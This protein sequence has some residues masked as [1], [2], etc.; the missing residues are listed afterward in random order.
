MTQSGS[1]RAGQF[2]FPSKITFSLIESTFCS[3]QLLLAQWKSICVQS[4]VR[5]SIIDPNHLF[6]GSK[7]FYA[8][9]FRCTNHNYFFLNPN[10]FVR[11]EKHFVI[12]TF[13]LFNQ[14]HFFCGIEVTFCSALSIREAKQLFA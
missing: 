2:G 4:K 8:K 10:H 5:L 7:S 1:L 12:I 13:A 3:I 11:N 9:R 14:N 6:A